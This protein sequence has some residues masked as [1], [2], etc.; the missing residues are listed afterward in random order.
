MNTFSVHFRTDN[1]IEMAYK[2][3]QPYS[4]GNLVQKVNLK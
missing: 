2:E 3:L 4:P 1:I